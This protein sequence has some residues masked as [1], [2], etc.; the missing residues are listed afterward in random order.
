MAGFASRSSFAGHADDSATDRHPLTFK[1]DHPLG[2]G[3]VIA[4]LNGRVT[5]HVAHQM[6]IRNPM[7]AK[8]QHL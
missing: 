4:T 8:K 3:Q 2:A 6:S 5:H 7:K 1:L